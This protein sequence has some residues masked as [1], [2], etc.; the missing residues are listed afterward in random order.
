[1]IFYNL[2]GNV[3]HQVVT[4]MLI[5]AMVTTSS[6]P[7]VRHVP[8]ATAAYLGVMQQAGLLK[9]DPSSPLGIGPAAAEGAAEM[10]PTIDLDGEPVG[11]LLNADA[12][13]MG[14]EDFD[15]PALANPMSI[16]RMQSAYAAT[17]AVSNTLVITF[18]VT[19]NRPPSIV[20]GV[21]PTATVTDTISATLAMDL[22]QDPNVIHNVLLADNLL[23]ANATFISADPMP[24]QEGSSLAW[25]LGDIPPLGSVTATLRLQR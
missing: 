1:M 12:L 14:E 9:S 13:K 3:L 21:S 6:V 2:L 18:T 4:Y 8:R 10:M 17:D 15:P 20:P 22:S 16:S 11:F 23:P 19:N 24:D 5:V 7:L 25:N